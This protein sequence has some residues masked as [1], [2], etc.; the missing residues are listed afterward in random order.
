MIGSIEP[1]LMQIAEMNNL[2]ENINIVGMIKQFSNILIE[3]FILWLPSAVIISSVV[4]G[5]LVS[6]V[7]IFF[8]KRVNV[9]NIKYVKFFDMKA[10]NGMCTIFAILYLISMFSESMSIYMS[11]ARN[12][13]LI[14]GFGI[15]VCG[16]SF[17]DWLIAKKIKSGYIRAIIYAAFCFV[18]FMLMPM[19]ISALLF[20]GFLDKT[21]KIRPEEV[22][23][24][25]KNE[26]KQKQ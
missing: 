8:L 10:T 12:M 9:K 20:A 5:Y 13:M 21:M 15:T 22:A 18:G 6:S 4:Y 14:L 3:S 7:G 1:V 25:D 2:P 24:E 26:D 23:G 11:A 19:L 16:F 17:V